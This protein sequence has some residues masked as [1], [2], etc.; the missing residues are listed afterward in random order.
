MTTLLKFNYLIFY[1]QVYLT[2]WFFQKQGK[3][4]IENKTQKIQEKLEY[5]ILRKLLKLILFGNI[6]ELF[7]FIDLQLNQNLN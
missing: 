4:E 5:K 6:S 1:L 7:L 3:S 2:S